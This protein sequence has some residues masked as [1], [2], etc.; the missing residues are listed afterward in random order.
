VCSSDL[1]VHNTWSHR[2]RFT[3]GQGANALSVPEAEVADWT[4]AACH[5]ELVSREVAMRYLGGLF[6]VALPGCP[7]CGQALVSEALAQGKMHQ[8][9]LLLED[10]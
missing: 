10:K 2:L 5:S 9:E 8:V 4:C 1:R 3:Q 6:H 7:R